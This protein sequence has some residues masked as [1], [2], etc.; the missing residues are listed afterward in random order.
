MTGAIAYAEV[1]GDPIGHSL[2][3]LIH[4]HWLCRS[5]APDDYRA[6][7]VTALSL[8]EYLWEARGDK[9]W[10]GCNVTAPLKTAILP[11]L[12]RLDAAAEAT[13]AVNLVVRDGGA[14]VGRNSDVAGVL[15]ALR[16]TDLSGRRAVLIGAG[17]AAAAAAHALRRLGINELVVL[18][19]RPDAAARLGAPE[20]FDRA[21]RA[22]DGASLVVNATPLGMTHAPAMPGSLL[23]AL[24][25]TAAGAIALDMVYRPLL[26]PFLRAARDRGLVAHDGLHMLIGQAR[27]A[28]NLFFGR[29]APADNSALRAALQQ[30]A[31]AS[32]QFGA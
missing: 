1:I 31:L 28:F 30:A 22:L 27:P 10:R 21:D 12:D 13:G 26:T 32:P 17:G 19:R 16:N 7:K 24:S 29:P 14:L 15:A 18:A 6:R 4:R 3:P 23:S 8:A 5:G 11:H 9:L 2:S 25:Q 20:T